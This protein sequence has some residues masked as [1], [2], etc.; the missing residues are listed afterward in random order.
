MIPHEY[1]V[2]LV[3]SYVQL[4]RKGR[5]YGGL[6]PFH[7]EKTPSFYVYPDTQSFYC[8]GCQAAGDAISF[9]KKINNISSGEAIKMLASR[10]GMPE[11]Q[12]DDKTGRLRSRVL[13]MNKEAA[14]FFHACLNSTVEEARQARAYWR[15]RGLDDKTIVRFGLGYAPNDGQALYQFLRDKGYNQQELDASGLFKRSPSG[16]IYCLFWKRVMTPI[17]D[18]RGNIIAFGGRVLDD[19]KPKYVN[20]PET[21]VYHKSDTVF[22]LQI[23]KRSASRRFVLCEGYMDVIALHQAGFDSA[24]ASLGTSLTEEQARIIARHTDRIV[25]SYDADGAGQAAAQ[26]A[27]DILKKCDLQV[28]V[29]RIPGAKDPDEFIKA[30]GADAFR[31]LIERSEDHNAFRIEQIAAK[32]DLEDDEARVLFLRDAARM[33]A[34][35]ESTIEREV[36]AGRAAKMAGV[37]AEA[38]NVEV[39]RELGIQRKRRKAAERREIRSPVGLAQPKDRSLAYTDMKSAKAEENVLRLLFS[40]QKLIAVAEKDLQPAWFS[41]P[42]LRKIYER[43]LELNR[44]DQMVDVLSF[45]GWLEPNEMSLL[46]AILE[47]GIPAGEHRGELQEYINTIRMQRVKDGTITQ[48]GEDPLLTFGRIKKQNAGGQT[49]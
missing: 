23:A 8:F 39:R 38:M 12:E 14:R 24:V 42:V 36:Y 22:A 7:S 41:A 40:D 10:A 47:P 48:A 20:S 17:F 43:V 11:P 45:E 37:T 31:N 27:I 13:S 28:K 1:I 9:V 2:E 26:R 16:R 15:R 3:G 29:L 30:R 33:L 49:I 34:G 4:K 5:L 32:Y 35:I 6:C 21:L 44:N 19:S 46:S 18:L 25:I